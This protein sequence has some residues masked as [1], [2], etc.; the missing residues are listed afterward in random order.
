MIP[1]HPQACPGRPDRLRWI[2]P[3]GVP[4]FTGPAAAVPAPLAAL[5]TDGTL[6]GGAETVVTGDDEVAAAAAGSAGGASSLPQPASAPAMS[7]ASN[8]RRIRTGRC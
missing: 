7:T 2:T 5:L 4:P 1:I 6:A 8:P 3:A